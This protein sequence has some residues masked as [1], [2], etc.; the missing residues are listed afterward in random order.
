MSI[1]IAKR[2]SSPVDR[3]HLRKQNLSG[4]RSTASSKYTSQPSLR[5]FLKRKRLRIQ[6]IGRGRNR[7]STTTNK[8]PTS[9]S[10]PDLKPNLETISRVHSNQFQSSTSCMNHLQVQHFS[11]QL[12]QTQVRKN[13]IEPTLGLDNLQIRPKIQD[14]PRLKRGNPGYALLVLL[15]PRELILESGQRGRK[16]RLINWSKVS[17]SMEW[18]DGKV[19]SITRN[20][21]F[22]RGE[23]IWILRIGM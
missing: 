7:S 18:E 20:C 17:Q 14:P 11:P 8:L 10:C 5:Q 6:K 4:R 16:K 1:S 22:A 2:T 12:R 15:P 3:E 19:S 9:F 23:Q 13:T 21:I